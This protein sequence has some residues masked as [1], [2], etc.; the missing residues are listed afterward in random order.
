MMKHKHIGP[1]HYA[2][3]GCM[4][5]AWDG[6]TEEEKKDRRFWSRI[7]VGFSFALAFVVAF[8]LWRISRR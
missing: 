2:C 5:E 8:V 7:L 4:R 6:L 3:D 1:E